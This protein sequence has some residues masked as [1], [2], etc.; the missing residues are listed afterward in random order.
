MIKINNTDVQDICNA[1]TKKVL[2]EFNRRINVLKNVISLLTSSSEIIKSDLNWQ[3][4]QAALKAVLGSVKVTSS[5]M[6]QLRENFEKYR[7]RKKNRLKDIICDI[8]EIRNDVQC[9]ISETPENLK[10]IQSRI[11]KY[12]RLKQSDQVIKYLFNYEYYY[13]NFISPIAEKLDLKVCPYCNRNYISHL[14]GKNEKRIIGPTF[15]HYFDKGKNP[16]LA[17]SFYNL[18]PSCSVCNSNLKNQKEFALDKHLHPYLHDPNDDYTFDFNLDLL[19]TSNDSKIVFRPIVDVLV[20]E[21]SEEFTRLKG[22][23]KKDS[24]S[25]NVFKLKEIYETHYDT[26]DEIYKKFDKNS[27]HYIRSIATHL[28]DMGVPEKEF[29]RYHFGNYYEKENFHKRP[30]AKLTK[31]IYEK[32]KSISPLDK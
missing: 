3:T 25:F 19:G 7:G 26:V 1:Y 17:L 11:K 23:D 4:D 20:P 12:T 13:A 16:Y 27:P 30:L 5:N 32:M 14:Q 24:G 10:V 2:V 21:N 29:Y 8:D 6:S 15:D 28:R 9:V 18:I 22:D 31:D